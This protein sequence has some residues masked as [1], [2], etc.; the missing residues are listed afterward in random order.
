MLNVK[1]DNIKNNLEEYFNKVISG[2]TLIISTHN[3]EKV[4]LISEK[5]Y[6]ELLKIKRNTEYL[7]MLDKSIE[8]YENGNTITKTIEDLKDLFNA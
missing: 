8:E 5:E 4:V 7:D 3:N 2:E 1:T 6:N